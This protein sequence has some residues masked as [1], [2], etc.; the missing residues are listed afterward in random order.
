MTYATDDGQADSGTKA[1]DVTSVAEP[2][3]SPKQTGL[4]T[5][6]GRHSVIFV[7]GGAVLLIVGMAV[8]AMTRRHRPRRW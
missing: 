5:L 3:A 7:G 8:M 2:A 4:L 1:P 6:T